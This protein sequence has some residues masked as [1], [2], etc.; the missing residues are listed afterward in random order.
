MILRQ[1]L[2]VSFFPLVR[3]ADQPQYAPS[4]RS[5]SKSPISPKPMGVSL[6][7]P[8]GSTL[9]L[10]LVLRI[11][12]NSGFFCEK[13]CVKEVLCL[14]H[15]LS[16]LSNVGSDPAKHLSTCVAL[17]KA[18]GLPLTCLKSCVCLS[19]LPA[20]NL[21]EVL[22]IMLISKHISLLH[23]HAVLGREWINKW[24]KER[25]GRSCRGSG[26]LHSFQNKAVAVSFQETWISHV[27]SYK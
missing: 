20:W 18:T 24:D 17:L 19:A 27:G 3:R 1:N 9:A 4:S 12:W 8:M 25:S 23:H 6:S 16:C 26:T 11:T 21:A 2:T 10:C 22:Y 5:W 14:R 13:S 15:N 7:A